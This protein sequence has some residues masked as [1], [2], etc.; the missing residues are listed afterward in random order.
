M[1]SSKFLPMLKDLCTQGCKRGFHFLRKLAPLFSVKSQLSA[2]IQGVSL[3]LV[4]VIGDHQFEKALL[5]LE[6][7]VN[8]MPYSVYEQ[9]RLG[10]RKPTSITLELAD[11]SVKIPRGII[12]DVLVKVDKF[13]FPADFIVLDGEP[14]QISSRKIPVILGR[15]FMATANT[16]IDVKKGILTMTVG[17][18]TVEF[19]VF[20]SS[21]QPP[22]STECFAVNM[23]ESLVSFLQ[24]APLRLV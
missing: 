3:F 23:I 10:E 15:P 2:R 24:N 14:I 20:K 19:N 8:L 21:Q 6:A 18:M 9:L 11:R 17:D 1:L 7:S 13:I 12:E 22:D 5:D 4:C 16:I